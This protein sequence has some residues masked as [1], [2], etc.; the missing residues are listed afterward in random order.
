MKYTINMLSFVCSF[1]FLIGMGFCIHTVENDIFLK[2]MLL[3]MAS[4]G[5]W[6]I[7]AFDEEK[8]Q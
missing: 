7:I 6:F 1:I 8:K 4:V 5:Y 3:C 2:I